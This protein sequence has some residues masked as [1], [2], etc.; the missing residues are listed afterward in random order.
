MGIVVLRVLLKQLSL[1]YVLHAWQMLMWH[2]CDYDNNVDAEPAM[3]KMNYA[4]HVD[5]NKSLSMKVVSRNYLKNPSSQLLENSSLPFV[6]SS[7]VPS[8]MS[9]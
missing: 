3:D 8:S 9:S 4:I 7:P 1:M 6:P 5:L 2:M